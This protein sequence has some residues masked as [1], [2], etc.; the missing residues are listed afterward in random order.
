MIDPLGPTD[1]D[2]DDVR[3]VACDVT[4]TTQVCNPPLRDTP[5]PPDP[6]EVG[7]PTAGAGLVGQL[8]V[9]VLVVA[10][11]LAIAWLIA[12]WRQGERSPSDE[13]DID[14]GNRDDE[15]EEDV[16]ARVVDHATPPEWWR[17]RASEHREQNRFRDAIRCEYRALVGDLARAGYVDEIPGRTS[18][19]ERAQVADLAPRLGDAGRAVASQFDVAADTFDIAWFDDGVIT[20]AD[21][22][23][24]LAAQRTVLDAVLSGA[25]SRGRR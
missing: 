3:D 16:G 9:V 13:D 10:L 1:L 12:R 21:D 15:I 7:D 18:G 24:F 25:R 8:V 20:A 23:R 5:N 19:E 2:P 22:Q 11:V 17:R 6:P 14:D 4:A